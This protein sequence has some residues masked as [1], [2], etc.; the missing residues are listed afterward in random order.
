M[1]TGTLRELNVKPGDVVEWNGSEFVAFEE[2]KPDD[3][4]GVWAGTE[5]HGWISGNATVRIIS[6]A[7]DAPTLWSEMTDAEKGALLLAQHN[8]EKI[9]CLFGGKW[10]RSVD[11]KFM[12]NTSYRVKPKPRTEWVRIIND[13]DETIATCTV[14][15]TDGVPDLSTIDLDVQN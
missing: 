9:D 2:P 5:S 13:N 11:P 10:Y 6:R 15:M 1:K 8:G 14:L 7:D 12:P 4:S 3:A